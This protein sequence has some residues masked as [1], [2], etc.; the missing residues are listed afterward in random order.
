MK[1]SRLPP[2]IVK[3]FTDPDAVEP[4]DMQQLVPFVES[5]LPLAYGVL[6]VQ[7]FH[8]SI[9]FSPSMTIEVIC[10]PFLNFYMEL[11]PAGSGTFFCC[12]SAKRE[13]EYSIFYSKH[14]P[15]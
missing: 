6:G 8:V 12:F 2:D 4:P 5:A 13:I 14:Y 9:T 15:W 11:F 1:V 10:C 3:Y 7:I